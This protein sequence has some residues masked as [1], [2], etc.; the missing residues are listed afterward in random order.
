MSQLHKKFS[1]EQVVELLQ[2]YIDKKIERKY[3]QDILGVK[4]AMFFR[5]LQKY[6]KN[7]KKFSIDYLRTSPQRISQ[8][9]EKNIIKELKIDKGIITDKKSPTDCYNYSYI[10]DRLADKYKQKVSLPTIIDRAK[11][12]DFYLPKKTKRRLMTAK[13]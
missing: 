10:K 9:I 7:P 8:G 5:V 11:K 13:F 2:R 1:T 12:N 3:I 4:K 6:R